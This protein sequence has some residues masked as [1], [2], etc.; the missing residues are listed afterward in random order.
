MLDGL[1]VRMLLS[2]RSFTLQWRYDTEAHPEEAS[3]AIVTVERPRSS[4]A[5]LS[6]PEEDHLVDS[7]EGLRQIGP[8]TCRYA[9]FRRQ[10]LSSLETQRN[11]RSSTGSTAQLETAVEAL[12]GR[13]SR[14]ESHLIYL[15]RL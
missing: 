8:L 5:K 13:K 10:V 14:L 9:S 7:D 3:A 11:F 1:V 12:A 15:D 6:R 4:S 2:V